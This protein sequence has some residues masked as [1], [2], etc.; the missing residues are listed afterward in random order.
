MPLVKKA[1]APVLRN[2]LLG[3]T[4]ATAVLVVGSAVLYRSLQAQRAS[5]AWVRHTEE[6]LRQLAGIETNIA[7]LKSQHRGYLLTGNESYLQPY[8]VTRTELQL[9]NDAL[10]R[11]VQ[12][13]LDQMARW[14]RLSVLV[15]NKLLYFDQSIR[16]YQQ[17]GQQAS[18]RGLVAEDN[19]ALNSDIRNILDLMERTE[20]FHL[21]QRLDEVNT[22]SQQAQ[23]IFIPG[24]ISNVLILLATTMF[25]VRQIQARQQAQQTANQETHFT[26]AIFQ[27]TQALIL[28]LDGDGRIVRWNQFCEILSGYTLAQV[29]HQPFWER[30]VPPE[31]QAQMQERFLGILTGSAMTGHENHWLTRTGEQ[32]LIRWVNT[33]LTDHQQDTEYVIATG[34]DVTEQQQARVALSASEA[35]YR[36]L[37]ENAHDLIQSVDIH[38][39]FIYVN[40]AWK[41][42]LGYQ[43]EQ[44]KN[45]TLWEVI[46][47][48]SVEHCRQGFQRLAEIGTLP[49]VELKVRNRDGDILLLEG[50]TSCS[51][52]DQGQP[53][54]TRGIF[55][56]VT[57]RK[58]TEAELVRQNRRAQILSEITLKIRQSLDL[59]VIL[60]TTAQEV[61]KI[62]HADRT[63]IYQLAGQGTGQV[64]AEARLATSP[65]I[66]GQETAWHRFVQTELSWCQQGQPV[67]IDDVGGLTLTPQ[68]DE[69]LQTLGVQSQLL[70]PLMWK[71][72]LWGMLVCHQC[73]TARIW[74]SFEQDLLTQLADQVG[75]ALTQV[76]LIQELEQSRLAAEE[77]SR[78]KSAF[79][80]NM[81]HEIR[82]P[83]NAVLGMTGL[84]L[85][86]PLNPEQR[87]FVNT[88][89][90][91]GDALLNLINEILD[92]SKL[93]A[94][95][96]ELEELDFEVLTVVEEVV[97]LLAPQAHIKG[98]EI[99]AL[100][101]P[102]TPGWVRGDATRLRQVLM[103]LVSNG[104]K[105][106]HT[107][108]VVI[109]VQPGRE[110]PWL[111]FSVSDTGIGIPP[112][113]QT[114]LFSPFTQADAS[115]TRKFGGTGLGLAI[116][117]QLVTLMGGEIG[118]ESTP[119]E[120]SRF[121]FS[122][123]LPVVTPPALATLPPPAQPIEGKVL[124]VVDDHPTNRKVV[125]YQAVRWGLQVEE[126]ASGAEALAKMH[127]QDYAV[128]LV[129]M[130]MPEMD[131]LTLGRQIKQDPQLAQ[132]PLVMLTSSHLRE[133]AK[134]ALDIGFAAH[135]VKPVK[136]SRL[137]DTI[138]NA[139]EGMV[140]AVP[141]GTLPPTP[142]TIAPTSTLRVLLAEDNPVNQKVALKQLESLG[143]SADVAAN[144][145]EALEMI[146]RFAYD[147][148][149]MDC[150]MPVLD[151]FDAT[152]RLH[153][154]HQEGRLNQRPVVVALT[155]NAMK[156]DRDKCLAAGMDDY[157]SKPVH[158]EDLRQ[159]L[160]HWQEVLRTNGG[161]VAQT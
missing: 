101:N 66:V 141:T 84:L 40:R 104:I 117:K 154:L 38:G 126:A 50:S 81:S 143:F 34:I 129:D 110:T 63:F 33:L 5:E 62:I 122:L 148:V 21:Q 156:E 109:R 1:L 130:N 95:Q 17:Q 119:G 93:E 155:A 142:A 22:F 146:L 2:V 106:T 80:A 161:A 124:L 49:F 29:N 114:R 72:E 86:T 75:V 8:E 88:V 9:A 26:E 36:D 3:F 123:P 32:R 116:C 60:Q 96:V 37:F 19:Q 147:L 13:N 157:L 48:D 108:E 43:D 64:V 58:R 18:I 6:V 73:H 79:L 44:I 76:Y 111:E 59:G 85:D 120:G 78:V 134:Q 135:L 12:D 53:V 41:R 52:D 125:R 100:V 127:Q 98:L 97:E 118:L 61:Q 42:A 27:T 87:D 145:Q 39:H 67:V 149:L 57:D 46:H 152:R 159:M 35:R 153:T 92:L 45:L 144:G 107:G 150:Q 158:K 99:A 69:L 82:T 10:R 77:S 71:A 28:A 4:A 105:F 70:V 139:L 102:Q 151:G 7:T 103:N 136:A 91:S 131:G 128:V 113:I 115:T 140:T 16:T 133:E 30:L 11:L 83:M 121:F 94:G 20:E 51:Y 65:T 31:E 14:Q 132:V 23:G 160:H 112:P 138:M 74:S 68:Q 56:D 55:R 24:L 15:A 25:V 90:V 137:L 54:A 89:R 47:P